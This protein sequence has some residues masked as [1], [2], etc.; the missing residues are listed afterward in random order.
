MDKKITFE[1]LV[2]MMQRLRSP[3][4]CPWDR[5]QTYE[6][7]GPMLLEEVYEVIESVESEDWDELRD[8]L[9]DLL[10]QIVFY[11][12]IAD[13]NKHFDIHQSIER[14]HTKMTRRH[15]HVFGNTEVKDTSEVLSNWEA[16]KAAERQETG[17]KKKQSE[18]M[19]DGTSRKLPSL[20]EATQIT[21]K[22]SRVGFDWK[23]PEYVFAK[24]EEEVGELHEAI[25]CADT[26]PEAVTEELGDLLFTVANLARLL[27]VEPESALKA[28]N[29]KFRTRFAHIERRLAETGK[30]WTETSLEEMDKYW[31]EAK[32]HF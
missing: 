28:A 19:L 17:K 26:N 20:I 1:D 13:E 15:P 31:D 32:K 16:I 11:G 14:V 29:K 18:S 21:T 25:K 4:G 8:E 22:A 5:E 24:I 23:K 9:G 12:Q 3:E 30:S 7:L 2:L 6:T 27:S 10:F